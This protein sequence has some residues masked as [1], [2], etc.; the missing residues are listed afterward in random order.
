MEGFAQKTH[1]E[2]T[3]LM[4][5]GFVGQC[6]KKGMKFGDQSST[7]LRE[8]IHNTLHTNNDRTSETGDI[9]SEANKAQILKNQIAMIDV[10][11][12][13]PIEEIDF[14]S[15]EER[16]ALTKQKQD[17]NIVDY[18]EDIGNNS[19]IVSIQPPPHKYFNR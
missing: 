14:L 8:T 3:A 10:L 17:A 6:R 9:L 18:N 11:D 4:M 5:A 2:R 16:T 1:P 15:F 12:E 13:M 19:A 7:I